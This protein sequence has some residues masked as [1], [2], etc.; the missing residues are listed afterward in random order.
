MDNG[1]NGFTLIE[2]LVVITII[3][4]L[5]ALILTALGKARRQAK[6]TTTRSLLS[7]I[8]MGCENYFS[9]WGG[10][11]PTAFQNPN[12]PQLNE[13][14]EML[15]R[16][17]TTR[18]GRSVRDYAKDISRDNI[19]DVD[20]D[21]ALEFI[22]AWGNPIVYFDSRNYG[23]T[24]EYRNRNNLTYTATPKKD[25]RTNKYFRYGKFMLWSF[26]IN[27]TNDDGLSEGGRQDDVSNF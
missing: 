5:A 27:E 26:G 18:E 21:S 23:K 1:K 15:Y 4:I 11:Y 25:P 3:S 8:S 20:G 12:S 6:V 14:A 2:M 24:C 16:Q 7:V 13:G 9:D 22:D 10:V 17:L 19:G